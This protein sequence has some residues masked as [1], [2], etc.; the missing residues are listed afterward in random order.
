VTAQ[1]E[2]FVSV[3]IETAGPI[4]GE[5]SPQSPWVGIASAGYKK[6]AI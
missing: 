6:A 1:R 5:Y 4:P 2:I 3:D